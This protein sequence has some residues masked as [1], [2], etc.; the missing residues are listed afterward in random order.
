MKFG[1]RGEFHEDG[2][3]SRSCAG[4]W[5]AIGCRVCLVPL[6]LR[7]GYRAL[8]NSARARPPL[9]PAPRPSP[10]A[11][12]TW[13]RCALL[14]AASTS[15]LLH[16]IFLSPLELVRDFSPTQRNDQGK[17]RRLAD[18]RSADRVRMRCGHGQWFVSMV[19]E[20]ARMWAAERA[21]L[22]LLDAIPQL[23]FAVCCPPG[24]NPRDRNWRNAESGCSGV[25]FAQEARAA[26]GSC[27]A[28]RNSRMPSRLTP[29]SSTST[30]VALTGS[31]FRLAPLECAN[32]VAHV[33]IFEDAVYLARKAG[34][35]RCLKCIIAVSS[36]MKKK[37]RANLPG[38]DPGSRRIRRIRCFQMPA[39]RNP[40]NSRAARL[41]WTNHAGEGPGILVSALALM[42]TRDV[43]CLVAGDG[44]GSYVK[45]IDAM[46]NGNARLRS[47]GFVSEV[48]PLLRSCS[49]LVCPS[50]REPLGR[51]IFEA[52]DAGAVPVVFAGSGGAAE[53]IE[54]SAGG[55]VLYGPN[56]NVWLTHWN[57]RSPLT[58]PRGS[59]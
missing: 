4:V 33:R 35:S 41:R 38:G 3:T 28:R 44:D 27:H 43:E 45:S 48:A 1:D 10:N 16:L 55:I 29:T 2:S 39:R 19:V 36:A 13:T 17:S 56:A 5:S 8:R 51:V 42:K 7:D 47:T 59:G 6:S 25:C 23:Q 31:L 15:S 24:R 40:Q 57:R 58:A 34:F 14:A 18:G 12:E 49:V 52:W 54:A 26:S 32:S 50:H 21:L 53:V 30:R 37:F 11:A 9:S 22:D 46:V 20:P